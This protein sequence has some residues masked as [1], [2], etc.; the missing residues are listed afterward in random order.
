MRRGRPEGVDKN[1]PMA[2]ETLEPGTPSRNDSKLQDQLTEAR[3]EINALRNQIVSTQI[4]NPN[5]G[6]ANWAV[7]KDD[8]L[9]PEF[10]PATPAQLCEKIRKNPEF[11]KNKSFF[12]QDKISFFK[13]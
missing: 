3:A 11:W 9:I 13:L 2:V 1:E 6:V 12:V 7:F 10:D 5:R 4:D 8:R